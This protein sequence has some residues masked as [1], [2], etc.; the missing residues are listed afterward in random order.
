MTDKEYME[1]KK[2]LFQ[3]VIGEINKTSDQVS[4]EKTFGEHSAYYCM[5]LQCAE[6]ILN[7]EMVSE[8]ACLTHCVQ[9]KEMDYEKM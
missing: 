1:L 7:L 5:G 8:P 6:N 3:R 4:K 9:L 2:Q